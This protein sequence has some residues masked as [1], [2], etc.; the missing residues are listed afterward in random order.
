MIYL[1]GSGRSG[2]TLIE[3][4]LQ[5]AYTGVG[6]GEVI[7][8]WQRGYLRNETC[9]CGQAFHDCPFWT[10]V[11][12]EGFGAV[13]TREAAEYDALF[14]RGRISRPRLHPFDLDEAHAAAFAT[15]AST[16]YGAIRSVAGSGV[17]IIDGSKDP[18]YGRWLRDHARIDVRFLH[19]FRHPAAVAHSWQ[20]WRARPEG[21]GDHA[22]MARSRWILGP[23]WRWHWTNTLAERV[24][25][26]VRRP[27]CYE[28]FCEQPDAELS[29]CAAWLGLT[30]RPPG[31]AVPEWHSVSGN[32]S[33]FTGALEAISLDER[34][35]QEMPAWKQRLV[36]LLCRHRYQRLLRQ[37][38]S[39]APTGPQDIRP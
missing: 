21:R 18:V 12:R 20:R 14:R 38:T 13:S 4:H 1:S 29:R 5:R 6:V 30:R 15:V 24:P 16:L 8:V 10:A 31:Q 7:Y 17:P 28:T 2:T 22:Q 11:M 19:V 9:S 27:M 34:W 32:P 35:Q 26:A 23:I 3:H 33:R 39:F 36:D 37:S 25:E